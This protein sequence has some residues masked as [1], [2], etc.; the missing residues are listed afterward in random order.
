MLGEAPR[1]GL[2]KLLTHLAARH[3]RDARERGLGVLLCERLQRRLL[4]S[5]TKIGR[6]SIDAVERELGIRERDLL[7]QSVV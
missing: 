5:R 4:N 7:P 2:Q 1:D 3:L 6:Q